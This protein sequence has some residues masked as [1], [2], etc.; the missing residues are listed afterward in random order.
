M[1]CR[2]LQHRYPPLL[3]ITLYDCVACMIVAHQGMLGVQAALANPLGR[4]KIDFP[5]RN[6]H[7]AMRN[8]ALSFLLSGEEFERDNRRRAA[9]GN[10]E[11]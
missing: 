11:R 7:K 3:M 1:Q 2:A 10:R 8:E 9:A 5:A 4:D 6:F